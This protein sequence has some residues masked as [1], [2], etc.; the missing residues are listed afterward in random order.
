AMPMPATSA[1]GTHQVSRVGR[2]HGRRRADLLLVLACAR[3]WPVKRAAALA[4]VSQATVMRR[5]REPAFQRAVVRERAA[6]ARRTRGLVVKAQAEAVERLRLLA[7]SA[8]E[9]VATRAA[10]LLLRATLPGRLAA[11]L[12]ADDLNRGEHLDELA[13][14]DRHEGA[15]ADL[16]DLDDEDDDPGPVPP[17]APA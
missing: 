13:E 4:K 10:G 15:A 11:E 1:N 7:R 8:D 16:E 3:G 17:R 5:L 14:L 2:Q 12:M 6:L 9:K